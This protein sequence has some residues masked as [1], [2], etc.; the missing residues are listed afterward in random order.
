MTSTGE[1]ADRER[2]A[3]RLLRASAEHSYDPT[4]DVAWDEPLAD[5]VFFAPPHRLSLYRTGL[6]EAMSHRQ[7]VELSRHEVASI[8]SVGIWFELVLMQMLLR[9]AYDLEPTTRHVQYALTEIADECRHSV[10]FGRM[11][12]RLGC[13]CYGPGRYEH[14]LGRLVKTAASG[15]SMFAAILIAEEILDALQREAMVD[16]T[17]QPLVRTVTRIHVVEESRHVRYARDELVRQMARITPVK[18]ELTRLFV[19]RSAYIIGSRLVHPDVY[20]AVGLD[21][22]AAWAAARSNPEYR[23][24]LRWAAR[25]LVAFFDEVGLLGGPG[26]LLWRRAGLIG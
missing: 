13:P 23:A 5:G 7:R 19:A 16:T 8:A 20:P 6:W 11:I 9:H 10:M 15:A 21:R 26:M 3:E 14:E 25:R 18:R 1:L 22:A 12:E 4:V 2:L 17:I 24:T